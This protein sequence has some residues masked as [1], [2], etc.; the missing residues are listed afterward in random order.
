MKRPL[1]FTITFTILLTAPIYSPLSWALP[2]DDFRSES[3][4]VLGNDSNEPVGVSRPHF[5]S[6][7]ALV[8]EMRSVRL[9][10][11]SRS[12]QT[13]AI[14]P[15]FS[16][17]TTVVG[18]AAERNPLD[19]NADGLV[20]ALD[21]ALITNYLN[22]RQ[23]TKTKADE[24]AFDANRDGAISPM[25][26]LTVINC[27]NGPDGCFDVN[28]IVPSPEI[29]KDPAV[30][31]V[32]NGRAASKLS[33]SYSFKSLNLLMGGADAF[34]IPFKMAGESIP[35]EKTILEITIA[36]DKGKK[37]SRCEAKLARP[38]WKDHV[39]P[40]ES[41][42]LVRFSECKGTAN[43]ANVDTLSVTMLASEGGAIDYRLFG[44]AT[45]GRT[46][47][48]P[49][50]V[51]SSSIPSLPPYVHQ[52]PCQSDCGCD[53][54]IENLGCGCGN[55]GP[56]GCDHLCGSL[57]TVDSC[58]VCGGVGESCTQAK[59][60]DF[61]TLSKVKEMQD[62]QSLYDEMVRWDAKNRNSQTWRM[63]EGE[64]AK[65]ACL[66][67]LVQEQISI[68]KKTQPAQS[69]VSTKEDGYWMNRTGWLGDGGDDVLMDTL[70]MDKAALDAARRVSTWTSAY[71][72]CRANLENSSCN[73]FKTLAQPYKLRGRYISKNCKIV[74][75]VDPG[76][77]CGDLTL[78]MTLS[79]I[80][81]QFDELA[82]TKAHV[83]RFR[84][85]PHAAESWVHWLIITHISVLF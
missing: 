57:K 63:F 65:L 14:L 51:V 32:Q 30:I 61:Y 27:L 80:S 23:Y 7:L 43:L 49:E 50:D 48:S 79:P 26:V 68:C 25:D 41:V 54:L 70:F 83:V 58:G 77:L 11:T 20:T 12:N 78:N 81:I 38:E 13:V 24:S 2:I 4:L 64:G 37:L 76:K 28:G 15:P 1:Q 29:Q 21:S 36:S 44:I 40:F 69:C 6:R 82:E 56:S 45:N 59:E 3:L 10:D 84:M 55:P 67:Q 22:E 85:N 62:L 16:S 73:Y 66:D 17:N 19:V 18:A 8:A 31:L 46:I 33:V 39:Q 75:Q 52:P 53:P 34:S 9:E 5:T 60:C 74:D 72:T 71:Y 35:F 47:S 42:M